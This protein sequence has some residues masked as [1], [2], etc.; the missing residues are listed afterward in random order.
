V[1]LAG[2]RVYCRSFCNQW[3]DVCASSFV[4][5]HGNTGAMQWCTQESSAMVC[6]QLASVAAD[7]SALC[8]LAGM[9][10]QSV[11]CPCTCLYCWIMLCYLCFKCQVQRTRVAACERQAPCDVV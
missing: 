9:T 6:S 1:S 8:Q 2:A 7:G 10:F 4:S 3:L 5:F 11:L